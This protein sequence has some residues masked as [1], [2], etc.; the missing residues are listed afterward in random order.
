MVSSAMTF[1]KIMS[2]PHAIQRIVP[3]R[4]LAKGTRQLP[5]IRLAVWGFFGPINGYP[6]RD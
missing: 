5:R 3:T 2:A 6:Q 4:W 1:T